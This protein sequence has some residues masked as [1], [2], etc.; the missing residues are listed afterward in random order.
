M[1]QPRHLSAVAAASNVVGGWLVALLTQLTLFPVIGLQASLGQH[2]TISLV[3]TT[4]S[5]IRSYALRR[6]FT[7][8]G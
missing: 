2:A 5:F 7:R 8:F 1:S 3:F 6:F 4:L